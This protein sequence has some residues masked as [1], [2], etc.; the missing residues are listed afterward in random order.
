MMAILVKLRPD[1]L[2]L[3]NLPSGTYTISED[4]VSGYSFVSISPTDTD[5]A[6]EGHQF[7]VTGNETAD[8][9]IVITNTQDTPQYPV[10]SAF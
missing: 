4:S 9:E 10:Y 2:S 5:G 7:V 1:T 8:I 3:E 6:T